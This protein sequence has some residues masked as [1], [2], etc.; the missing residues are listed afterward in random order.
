M[1][2]DVGVVSCW[3]L[4]GA[5]RDMRGREVWRCAHGVAVWP[6][7]GRQLA[8]LKMPTD[9]RIIATCGTCGMCGATCGGIVMWQRCGRQIATLKMTAD[10]RIIAKCG[11]VARVAVRIFFFASFGGERD[12]GNR[13]VSRKGMPEKT[14]GDSP[15]R[16]TSNRRK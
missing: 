16:R 5:V 11:G 13:R 15:P 14:G 4:R 9:L 8:T 7:C 6:Q 10:L 1:G 2:R 3:A 12:G